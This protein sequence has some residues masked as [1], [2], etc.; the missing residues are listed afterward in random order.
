M[1][2]ELKIVL[3]CVTIIAATILA[4]TLLFLASWKIAI[5]IFLLGYTRTIYDDLMTLLYKTEDKI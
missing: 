2:K 1:N 5:G 4:Y 3:L